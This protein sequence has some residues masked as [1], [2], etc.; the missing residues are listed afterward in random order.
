MRDYKVTVTQTTPSGDIQEYQLDVV[1][2]SEDSALAMVYGWYD[3]HTHYL[4]ETQDLP[5]EA[6]DDSN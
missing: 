5:T 2:H 1:G 3:Q 4:Q 6:T